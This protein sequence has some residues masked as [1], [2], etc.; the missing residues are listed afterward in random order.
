MVVMLE[1]V[2]GLQVGMEHIAGDDE[3]EFHYVVL[4]NLVILRFVF[5]KMKQD[6]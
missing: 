5:M 2:N 4:L 3:D 6:E 1:L